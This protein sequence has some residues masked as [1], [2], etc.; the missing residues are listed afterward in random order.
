MCA[1][2]GHIRL[3]PKADIHVKPFLHTRQTWSHILKTKLREALWSAV[4]RL[5]WRNS[6]HREQEN[7]M[8]II[9]KSRGTVS[10]SSP[11]PKTYEQKSQYAL[12]LVDMHLHEENPDR[13]DECIKLYTE[14]A[15]WDA[16]SQR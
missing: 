10:C 3:T 6:W 2:K 4:D 16:R 8:N 7:I 1:A 14:D 15:I 11:L 5:F 12:D 13:V 9:E